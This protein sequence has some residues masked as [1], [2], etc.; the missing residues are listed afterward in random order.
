VLGPPDREAS[1][2]RSHQLG[3][4][5]EAG[6]ED[7]NVSAKPCPVNSREAASSIRRCRSSF[8]SPR[9]GVALYRA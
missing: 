3:E 7:L 1:R 9:L 8:G 6:S 2:G 5:V 4:W